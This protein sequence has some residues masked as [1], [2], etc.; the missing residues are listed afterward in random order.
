M[1]K[2]AWELSVGI[3]FSSAKKIFSSAENYF[4]SDGIIFSSDERN[5]KS[6]TTN[7]FIMKKKVAG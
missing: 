6:A 5:G 1:D 4:S 7:Q 3:N 2:G